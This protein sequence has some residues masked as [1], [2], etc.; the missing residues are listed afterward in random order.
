[1][2]LLYRIPLSASKAPPPTTNNLYVWGRNQAGQLGDGTTTNRSS[3][4]FIVDSVQTVS[5]SLGGDFSH[6]IKSGELWGS[7]Y[8]N[9]GAIGDNSTTSVS[10]PVQVGSDT[11][12]SNVAGG[13]YHTLA[14]KGGGFGAALFAWG[15]N[16]YGGLGDGTTNGQSSPVQIG[17]NTSWIQISASLHSL[18]IYY[19]G[20]NYEI[21]TLWAWGYNGF[22]ELG[23]GDTTNRSS[24]VQV[25]S[26]DWWFLVDAGY[27]HSAAIKWDAQGFGEYSLWTWGYNVNGQLGDGTTLDRSSPVQVTSSYNR[28]ISVSCGFYH[29]AY[30]LEDSYGGSLWTFGGNGRG[31]LGDGTTTDRSSPVQVGAGND[32]LYVACGN[33][34]TYALKTD[35]TLWAWGWG[36]YGQLGNGTSGFGT[37]KSSPVQ[38][39]SLTTWVL[40]SEPFSYAYLSGGSNTAMAILS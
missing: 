18:G 23:L 3:P 19:E 14:L 40:P 7:G 25:G 31:Q 22:G 10:S 34:N 8:N 38:V 28:M 5:A 35:G 15:G 17:A 36:F 9:Y 29:T 11:D 32:W 30:I 16:F 6:F 39:G 12:W 37:D 27:F 4:I 20:S 33:D 24:P 26:D 21:G 1:M 2:P 13:T